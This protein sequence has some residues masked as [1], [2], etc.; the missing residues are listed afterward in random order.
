MKAIYTECRKLDFRA[1]RERI[2]KEHK[3]L[4]KIMN[5]KIYLKFPLNM[6]VLMGQLTQEKIRRKI[7]CT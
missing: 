5:R 7:D 3:Y 1:Q 4:L 2:P 6:A